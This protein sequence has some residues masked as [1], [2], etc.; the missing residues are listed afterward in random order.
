MQLIIRVHFTFSFFLF[1][2]TP[3]SLLLSLLSFRMAPRMLQTA[4]VAC[5]AFLLDSAALG[6]HVRPPQLP[7][8][9]SMVASWLPSGN[10]GCSQYRETLPSC[11][12]I[13]PPGSPVGAGPTSMPILRGRNRGQRGRRNCPGSPSPASGDWARGGRSGDPGCPAR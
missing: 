1:Y 10:L 7:S 11:T 6:N 3:S 2:I 5:V 4:H 8:E 13:N 12:D 9:G